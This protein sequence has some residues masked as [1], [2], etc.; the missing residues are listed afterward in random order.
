[1]KKNSLI[2]ITLLLV[3]FLSA[4]V[5]PKAAPE[6]KHYSLSTQNNNQ[7]KNQEK[8]QP[9]DQNNKTILRIVPSSIETQYSGK[10]FVYHTSDAQFIND[11]YNQFLVAPDLQIT[12]VIS[13][14]LTGSVSALVISGDSL[15]LANYALQLKIKALYAD[16]QNK[17]QPIAITT[18]QADIYKIK[19]GVTTFVTSKTFEQK[20]TITANNPDDLI[21]AYDHNFE[22]ISTNLSIFVNNAID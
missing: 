11:P 14:Y 22:N 18:L 2:C 17:S 20:Q 12:N 4:C 7:S 19:N 1:M 9:Q 16:Y 21:K 6:I 15:L 3:V 10:S 13:T 5:S 8:N